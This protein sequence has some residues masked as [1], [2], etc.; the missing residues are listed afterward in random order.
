MTM[1]PRVG[2]G[3]A[4]VSGGSILLIHRLAEPEAGCWGLPGGKVDPGETA[5]QAVRREIAEELG[6][7]IALGA[8]LCLVEQMDPHWVSPV[9]LASIVAGEPRVLEPHKHGGVCWFALD[10]LP[11]PLT[12]ATRVAA[13]ALSARG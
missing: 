12:Q 6:V 11:E 9:Y 3:A 13:E 8:L 10:A 1:E 7:E 2:C 4:I 5:A